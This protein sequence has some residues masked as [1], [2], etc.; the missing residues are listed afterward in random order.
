MMGWKPEIDGDK[1][2]LLVHVKRGRRPVMLL[3]LHDAEGVKDKGGVWR[4]SLKT[5]RCFERFDMSSPMRVQSG[6][7]VAEKRASLFCSSVLG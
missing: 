7:I 4:W 5:T 3:V 2:H 1:W 6:L